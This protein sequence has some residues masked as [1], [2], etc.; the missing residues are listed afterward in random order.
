M[1]SYPELQETISV[2]IDEI[3]DLKGRNC[4]L[5]DLLTSL[6]RVNNELVKHIETEDIEV[7]RLVAKDI[8]FVLK[9]IMKS[10]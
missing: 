6:V 5:V 4:I 10:I 9:Q 2:L 3:H 7:V 8:K 1:S